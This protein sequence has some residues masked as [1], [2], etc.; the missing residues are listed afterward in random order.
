MDVSVCLTG[1]VHFL[2]YLVM[3]LYYVLN[4]IN[5]EIRIIMT[6]AKLYLIPSLTTLLS[7]PHIFTSSTDSSWAQRRN[8]YPTCYQGNRTD[9]HYSWSI[10]SIPVYCFIITFIKPETD[11]A[12]PDS[13]NSACAMRSQRNFSLWG[14]GSA[15]AT[16]CWL[17]N[18]LLRGSNAVQLL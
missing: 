5:Q 9:R 2:I 11:V 17:H 1:R 3:C 14:N 8:M 4:W 10:A 16:W 7:N 6:I 12:C 13:M 18:S 15:T